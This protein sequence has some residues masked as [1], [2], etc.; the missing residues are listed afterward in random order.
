MH[1]ASLGM[2]YGLISARVTT[3]R[4][5]HLAVPNDAVCIFLY[6]YLSEMSKLN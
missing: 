4:S 3:S 6:E 1:T 2:R 5:D